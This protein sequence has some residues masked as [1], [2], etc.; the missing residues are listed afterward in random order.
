MGRPSDARERLIA[1]ARDVIYARSYEAATVDDLCMAARVTKSSFYHF[2]SSK[3]DLVLAALDSMWQWFQDALVRPAFAGDIPP[4]ERI[5][6]FFDLMMEKQQ[7]QRDIGGYMRG[8]PLGN[9]TLEMSTQDE[10]IRVR[11]AQFFGEWL[12]YCERALCEAKEEGIVPGSLDVKVTAQALLAYFE[13]VILLAKG[14]NDPALMRTL[15]DGVLSLMQCG[16]HQHPENHQGCPRRQRPHRAVSK[17][18]KMSS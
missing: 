9:L 10:L 1:A 18:S 11:V 3:Q 17:S 5:L 14:R 13:G 8:C 2:F 15:R 7:A 12:R 6:R 16:E 4:H